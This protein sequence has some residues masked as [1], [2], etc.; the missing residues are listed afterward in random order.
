VVAGL[1]D[2]TVTVDAGEDAVC[3]GDGLVVFLCRGPS[4]SAGGQHAE[5]VAVGVGHRHPVGVV[6]VDVEAGGAEGDEAL[7]LGLLVAVCGWGEVEVE[8][9]LSGLDLDGRAA[10]GDLGAAVW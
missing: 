1:Y 4:G 3:G 8:P 9:V 7:D 5:L 10:P 6:P 2:Q